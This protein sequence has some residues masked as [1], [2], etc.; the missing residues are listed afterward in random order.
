MSEQ[1]CETC[2]FF[3]SKKGICRRYPRQRSPVI[4]WGFSLFSF[5]AFP[6]AKKS[7]WCGEYQ[8]ASTSQLVEQPK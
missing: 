6:D 4:V 8:R 3:Y 2:A 5:D 1:S 7:D